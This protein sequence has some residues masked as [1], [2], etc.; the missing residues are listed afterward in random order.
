MMNRLTRK[1]NHNVQKSSITTKLLPLIPKHKA[2][3]KS[4]STDSKLSTNTISIMIAKP[5]PVVEMKK[6][7]RKNKNLIDINDNFDNWNIF[8]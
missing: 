6:I 3:Q 8:F 4:L 2:I 7:K 1:H 5:I